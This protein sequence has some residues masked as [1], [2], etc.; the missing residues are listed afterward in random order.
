MNISYQISKPELDNFNFRD[1][2]IALP[3][4]PP[5]YRIVDVGSAAPIVLKGTVG[6]NLCDWLGAMSPN[7]R[8]NACLKNSIYYL[9]PVHINIVS[10]KTGVTTEASVSSARRFLPHYI[11][12][13]SNNNCNVAVL[14]TSS[15]SPRLHQPPS[16]SLSLGHRSRWHH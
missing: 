15:A 11:T 2:P 3:L 12:V 6:Q 16:C 7:S 10:I 5:A 4:S 8:V 9:G 14:D 1:L 13:I